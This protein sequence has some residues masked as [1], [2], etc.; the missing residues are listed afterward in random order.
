MRGWRR[1]W[2]PHLNPHLLITE[3]AD[4]IYK[5]VSSEC[6][7]KQRGISRYCGLHD[8]H[9]GFDKYSRTMY[10]HCRYIV[11]RFKLKTRVQKWGNSIALR[12][13]KSFA[14][15]LGLQTEMSV[16]M[17]LKEGKLVITPEI[18]P[19]PTLQQLLA[20]VSGENLHHEV[21]VGSIVG[22]ETW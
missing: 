9:H 16:E 21:D 1:R 22:K 10:L 15:D 7:S 11:R 8:T 13:P 12:I 3:W 14:D 5:L 4:F 19:K 18:L 17:S 20:K 2:I 6:P